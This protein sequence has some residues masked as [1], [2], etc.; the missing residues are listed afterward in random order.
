MQQQRTLDEVK[1]EAE[2]LG[3]TLT[4]K[5]QFFEINKGGFGGL[6]LNNDVD[7]AQ[8]YDYLAR[9]RHRLEQ[10]NEL[11]GRRV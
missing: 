7:R 6:F 8:A 5:E 11:Q 10:I 9:Y 2:A 1:K 3:F 4:L